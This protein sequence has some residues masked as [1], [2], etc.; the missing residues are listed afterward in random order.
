MDCIELRED[1]ESICES[2]VMT[3]CGGEGTA[4]D[5]ERTV[6]K[7]VV[8]DSSVS[9]K[10]GLGLYNLR[11]SESEKNVSIVTYEIE[12]RP[13]KG[14]KETELSV[15]W[16]EE[17]ELNPLNVVDGPSELKDP[18]FCVVEF[19]DGSDDKGVVDTVVLNE[20]VE[21]IVIVEEAVKETVTVTA[22][23]E[24]KADSKGPLF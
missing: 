12:E 13:R 15:S 24:L 19:G 20:T 6:V 4:D 9:V 3:L 2:D 7:G 8:K 10:V 5:V 21:V 23:S 22:C 14:T 1:V 11:I 18:V 17:A 16:L